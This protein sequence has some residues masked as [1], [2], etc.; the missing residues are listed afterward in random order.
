VSWPTVRIF[1]SLAAAFGLAASTAS[2]QE[3]VLASAGP[4]ALGAS[5]AQVQIASTPALA[6]AQ[7]EPL[8][9]MLSGLSTDR[10]PGV[11]Y[12]VAIGDVSAQKPLGYI[13]FFNAA[14]A[15]APAFTFPLPS[16]ARLSA[17]FTLTITPASP[18]DPNA[19]PQI[20]RIAVVSQPRP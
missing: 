20:G 6:R 2:A 11:L 19:H 15:S 13:N 17:G 9:L 10:P 4:V 16:G 8:T 7:G 1:A 18:P 3:A 12:Q 5:G 14:S